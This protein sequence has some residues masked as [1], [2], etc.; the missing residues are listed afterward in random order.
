MTTRLQ[1][2]RMFLTTTAGAAVAIPFLPSI[3]GSV[4]AQ[5]PSSRCF[6]TVRSEHGGIWPDR[7]YPSESTL[8][9]SVSILGTG[10]WT[11]RQAPLAPTS[12]GV[13]S[14]L[15]PVFTADAAA[16]DARIASKMSLLLGI[17]WSVNPGHNTACHLGGYAQGLDQTG[18]R[19]FAAEFKPTIDHIIAR[20]PGFYGDQVPVSHVVGLAAASYWH[21][22]PDNHDSPIT[23]SHTAG[24]VSELWTDLFRPGGD[25]LR[26]VD[27]RYAVDRALESYRRLRD[28]ASGPGRRLSRGDRDRLDEHMDRLSRLEANITRGAM[29]TGPDIGAHVNWHY[30]DD[31]L[32]QMRLAVETIIAAIQCGVCRV[33]SLGTSLAA[34]FAPYAHDDWHQQFPHKASGFPDVDGLYDATLAAEAGMASFYQGTFEHLVLPLLRGL[35]I[36]DGTGRNYLDVSLV[37]WTSEAGMSTHNYL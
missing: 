17:D 14:S 32:P 31:P 18:E 15:S 4:S 3:L 29:C 9:D 26:P 5:A 16:L 23:R 22:L 36:D 35:D 27:R 20:S 19:D 7:F 37:M 2:R 13:R 12:D 24:S 1:G 33:F 10:G 25:E 34:L 8:T 6:L 11:V 21:S 30:N 28:G